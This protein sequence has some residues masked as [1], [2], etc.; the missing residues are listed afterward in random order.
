LAAAGL[1]GGAAKRVEAGLDLLV[2]GLG[3]VGVGRAD[4]GLGQPQEGLVGQA[5]GLLRQRRERLLGIDPLLELHLA[6]AAP[7]LHLRLQRRI[8]LLLRERGE[9]RQRLGKAAVLVLQHAQEECGAGDVVGRRALDQRLQP[10]L[11]LGIVPEL[12][13]LPQRF[14]GGLLLGRVIGQHALVVRG[15]LGPFALLVLHPGDEVAGVGTEDRIAVGSELRQRADG[16]GVVL[17]Q[18]AGE[19][20]IVQPQTTIARLLQRFLRHEAGGRGLGL[21]RTQA[22]QLHLGLVAAGPGGPLQIDRQLLGGR[23]HVLD[24]GGELLRGAGEVLARFVEAGLGLGPQGGGL[25]GLRRNLGEC[26]HAEAALGQAEVIEDER[27]V[28]Q[29][30]LAG[31]RRQV[32]GGPGVVLVRPLQQR[33][34]QT[35]AGRGGFLV[36]AE[37][38]QEL[39]EA[40][41]GEGVV[42]LV[43]GP[44]SAV[45]Q[46]VGRL[47]GRDLRGQQ[48]HPQPQQQQGGEGAAEQGERNEGTRSQNGH[49]EDLRGSSQ[50][51]TCQRDRCGPA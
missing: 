16:G 12:L 17:Q 43:E 20:V 11:F 31:Q 49:P 5:R 13:G 10:G 24:A 4:L 50:E 22:A 1:L 41:G 21:L 18:E 33:Q 45:E 19:A 42:L 3:I 23:V 6:E 8:R 35:V 40:L 39:G 27:A 26:L 30:L 44:A 37:L 15:G 25:V 7:Q 32:L 51:R 9:A 29:V 47:V 48:R 38:R 36:A 34:G 2:A 14:L 28:G 46:H